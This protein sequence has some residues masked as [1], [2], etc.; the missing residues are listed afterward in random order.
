MLILHIAMKLKEIIFIQFSGKD[1]KQN[2][3]AKV[4][5]WKTLITVARK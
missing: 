3:L 4:F 2:I 5:R 1:A